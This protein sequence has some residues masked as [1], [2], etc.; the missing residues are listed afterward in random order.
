M[1]RKI[2]YLVVG[3]LLFTTV[4][5][6]MSAPNLETKSENQKSVP[7]AT[8]HTV[9]A[10]FG[11]FTTCTYC[12][13]AHEA[14]IY[15]FFNRGDDYPFYYITH[16]YDVNAH[17]Y[18]RVKSELGLTSSP[19]VYWDGGWRKDVGSPNNATAVA[20]Y[21]KS[22]NR[23]KNKTVADIDLSVEGTW[24]GA[25]NNK[26]EDGATTVPIDQIMKWNNSEMV[27]NVSVTNN[28]ASLQLK[29]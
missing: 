25:V 28:K 19:T 14:L 15:L 1:R 10:E 24:L 7:T 16:V 27:V 5:V 29:G 6:A 22:I 4:I 26:P 11:T 13:Y 20:D 9:L 21:K 18:G 8:T 17:A 3:M 2:V 12:K 23:C